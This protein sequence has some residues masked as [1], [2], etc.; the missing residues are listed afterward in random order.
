MPTQSSILIWH[1]PA[2]SRKVASAV[3][4]GLAAGGSLAKVE[5]RSVLNTA[6]PPASSPGQPPHKRTRG[7]L[8]AQ[9]AS[10]RTFPGGV[11][12]R[13]GVKP[14]SPV[15]A[16]A[17]ALARGTS[18]MA[19]RPWLDVTWQRVAGRVLAAVTDSVRSAL[20]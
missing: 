17:R 7:L 19:A 1:G 11:E 13:L 3:A 10:L 20:R 16:Q 2:I 14:G 4:A 5:A 12:L 8:Q 9:D 15:E 6:Y 18:R